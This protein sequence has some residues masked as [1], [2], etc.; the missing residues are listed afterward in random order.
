LIRVL[1]RVPGWLGLILFKINR[2]NAGMKYIFEV[3]IKE[4]HTAEEYADAWVR[5][6]EIIQRAYGARG[7]A[8][9]RKM[10]DPNVLIAIAEWA[11]KEDRDAMEGQHNPEVDAIIRGAAHLCE[12][13][14]LG[15]FADPEWVV[16][17]PGRRDSDSS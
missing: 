10:D 6:S 4:G 11:S 2:N 17:P 5:A 8:L 15:E 16:L 7:T 1:D 14:P 13:R 9:H 3:H 12:I